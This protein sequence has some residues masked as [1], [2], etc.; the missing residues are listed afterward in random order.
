MISEEPTS[1]NTHSKSFDLYK[2]SII[3]LHISIII[4]SFC[5]T[6]DRPIKVSDSK[7]ISE[8]KSFVHLLSLD[9]C[10]LKSL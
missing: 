8:L 7:Y 10:I 3:I 5:Q 2:W 4:I 1:L 9:P 6:R